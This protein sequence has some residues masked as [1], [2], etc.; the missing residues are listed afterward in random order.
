MK[1]YDEDLAKDNIDIILRKNNKSIRCELSNIGLENFAEPKFD[2]KAFRIV[3]KEGEGFIRVSF[4]KEIKHASFDII[5]EETL[6]LLK[7][8][9]F[10]PIV[11]VD[12]FDDE[13]KFLKL[14]TE[15]FNKL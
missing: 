8:M 2:F 7:Q 3:N 11:V 4:N 9:N 1:F 13:T 14:V 6:N 5:S 15:E 12:C 10:T